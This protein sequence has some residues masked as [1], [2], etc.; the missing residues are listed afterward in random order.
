MTTPTV[1]LSDEALDALNERLTKRRA[2]GLSGAHWFM[3]NAPD[4]D[5]I[6]AVNAIAALCARVCELIKER[7]LET[8]RATKYMA[9]ADEQEQRADRAE[10]R[11][12]ELEQ[13]LDEERFVRQHDPTGRPRY[14]SKL[15]A[16]E[17]ALNEARS[18]LTMLEAAE[19]RVA[20]LE[21]P[22]ASEEVERVADALVN[23]AAEPIQT[24]C[25]WKEAAALLR[26]LD[27]DL[28]TKSAVV[29]AMNETI[30]NLDRDLARVS[31][32][33]DAAVSELQAIAN[34]D[35]S[36][37]E[38]DVRDQFQLWAQNRARTAI[39]ASGEGEG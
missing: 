22:V 38:K 26:R 32:E 6:D 34:A 25:I 15:E 23:D 39:A 19:A 12:R 37:W 7:Q 28:Q 1:D 9:L 17:A 16:A 10:A 30:C 27:R 18:R 5:C 24:E 8:K 33:R 21:R 35:P 4:P 3:L 31:A 13:T 2:F 14:Q 11:V 29:D 36:K 20:E